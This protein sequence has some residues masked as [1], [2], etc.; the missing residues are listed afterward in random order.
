MPHGAHFGVRMREKV[1]AAHRGTPYFDPWLVPLERRDRATTRSCNTKYVLTVPIPKWRYENNTDVPP[2]IFVKYIFTLFE[3][4]GPL[5]CKLCNCH[6]HVITYLELNI[7]EYHHLFQ[8]RKQSS[9]GW[10]GKIYTFLTQ[11]FAL[12]LW[13]NRRNNKHT[14]TKTG[15]SYRFEQAVT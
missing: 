8:K 13:M 2:F 5:W 4:F 9:S 3:R 14:L 6:V 15:K 1:C 12:K 11:R 10:N 7:N